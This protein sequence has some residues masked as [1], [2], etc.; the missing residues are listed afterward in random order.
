MSVHFAVL[1]ASDSVRRAGFGFGLRLKLRRE[2]SYGER[3]ALAEPALNASSATR[4]K[5]KS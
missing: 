2:G 3:N 1:C 4:L 5:R